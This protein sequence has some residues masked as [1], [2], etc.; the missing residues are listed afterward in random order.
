V[1]STLEAAGLT[2]AEEVARM[3]RAG[4]V[5]RRAERAEL[6]D[7]VREHG[8]EH[9]HED[10]ERLARTS[11]R[12]LVGEP[13]EGARS[14]FGGQ[15]DLPDSAVW[16]EW[17]GQRLQF[18]LQVALDE[19]AG[20]GVEGSLPSSGTLFV[21]YTRD[22]SATG[23]SS[24]HSGSCVALVAEAQPAAGISTGESRQVDLSVQ[25]MLPRV[26]AGP[27]EALELDAGEQAAWERVR[28]ELAGLQGVDADE[29]APGER[30]L[31]RLGG[32][33]DD[34]RGGMPELC[35]EHAGAAVD[36]WDLLL[37]LSAD[38][39]LD[40]TWTETTGE[41]LYVWQRGPVD[42]PGPLDVWALTR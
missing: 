37:Q 4:G 38:D 7:L 9:R 34:K 36:G 10:V 29:P 22:P 5:E 20:A 23:L 8:L 35:D 14:R 18:L 27:V 2:R 12:L 19:L 25:L 40:W 30:C 13:A 11:A 28:T 42:G 16:P 39:E 17:R 21:F 1:L 3:P 33:P 24:E 31:H 41:R 32:Y 15:P 6:A 26:W